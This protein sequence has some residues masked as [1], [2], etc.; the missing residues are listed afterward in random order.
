MKKCVLKK[1]ISLFLC[2][3]M[4]TGTMIAAQPVQAAQYTLLLSQAKTIAL[5]NSDSYRQIKSKI[6]LKE[7]S[8]KQAVKSIQL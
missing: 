5:A 6:S 4:L 1:G 7:V 2:T 8:Y 3:V